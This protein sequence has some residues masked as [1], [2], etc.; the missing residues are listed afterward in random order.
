[1]YRKFGLMPITAYTCITY[2]TGW[3]KYYQETGD[4]FLGPGLK[5]GRQPCYCMC[6]AC[7]HC[8]ELGQQAG[9]HTSWR[10]IGFWHTYP[11]PL[12]YASLHSEPLRGETWTNNPTSRSLLYVTNLLCKLCY[13]WV[14]GFNRIRQEIQK[15]DFVV[16]W[17]CSSK[18]HKK[19]AVQIN[20]I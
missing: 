7:I 11:L 9:R 12:L 6:Y 1:M 5:Q 4:L 16:N 17:F 14:L 20:C 18:L 15:V 10:I 3:P 8:H 2:F 13:L 19:K